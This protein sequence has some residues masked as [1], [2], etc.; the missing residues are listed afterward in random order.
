MSHWLLKWTEGGNAVLHWPACL[1]HPECA[2]P[3]QGRFQL[4]SRQVMG[5]TSDQDH[6]P[7]IPPLVE[8]HL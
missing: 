1:G 5:I 3:R 4:W 2:K 6:T 7:A 8:S